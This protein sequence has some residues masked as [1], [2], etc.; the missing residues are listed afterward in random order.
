MNGREPIDVD[1][2][3][4]AVRVDDENTVIEL[5]RGRTEPER[6]EVAPRVFEEHGSRSFYGACFACG[7]LRVR[8]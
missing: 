7:T 1:L 2:L 6:R 5:F 8:A 3:L 4:D